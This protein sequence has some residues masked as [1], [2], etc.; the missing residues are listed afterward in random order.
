MK[1]RSSKGRDVVGLTT[2]LLESILNGDSSLVEDLELE[3][4]V[5]AIAANDLQI[6]ELLQL[7]KARA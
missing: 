1:G 4:W 2:A 5:Q 6:F 3:P 7:A